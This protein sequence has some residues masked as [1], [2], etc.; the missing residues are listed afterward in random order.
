MTTIAA[1]ALG[2]YRSSGDG[3][4]DIVYPAI[5]GRTDEY[6]GPDGTVRTRW[7][8]VEV[9]L[10]ALGPDGLV[11]RRTEPARLLRNEGA[12]ST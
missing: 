3:D 7:K 8:Q 1:E 5:P 4:T 10:A 9:E 6:L 11:A 12:T 2:A